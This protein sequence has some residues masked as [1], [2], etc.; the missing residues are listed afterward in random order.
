VLR[1]LASMLRSNAGVGFWGRGVIQPVPNTERPILN[2]E[3]E[4]V[5]S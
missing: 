4:T 2:T 1:E 5:R 3:G